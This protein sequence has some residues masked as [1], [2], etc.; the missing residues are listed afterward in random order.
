MV[1]RVVA[2]NVVKFDVVDLVGSLGLE[3]FH[4]DGVFL[5]A[6]LH[7]EVVEN[8]SETGEGDEAGSA[9]VLVLEVGL[10]EETSVLD[11]YAES[12][13]AC[14]QNLLFCIVEYVLRV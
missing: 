10:D 3:A 11:I 5:F 8:G 14:N 4:N 7:S 13:E 9:F 2:Q 12:L 6:Q 1:T